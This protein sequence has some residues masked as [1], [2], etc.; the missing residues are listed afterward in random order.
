MDRSITQKSIG[1]AWQGRRGLIW[2]GLLFAG[3]GAFFLVG[4]FGP[5]IL[6]LVRSRN[7][8]ATPCVIVSRDVE[9]SR[10]SDGED[11]YRVVA[12][13]RYQVDGREYVGN[14]DNWSFGDSSGHE[15][16]RRIV[17][18]L[19]AG[20]DATCY[21][22]PANPAEA[23]LSR[24][25]GWEAAFV[26]IPV[27]FIVAG[28]GMMIAGIW[29]QPAKA[30]ANKAASNGR[31]TLG[32]GLV[33][34]PQVESGWVGVWPPPAK[35]RGP[36]VLS[37]MDT[38]AG[39]VAAVLAVIALI[40]NG[41]IG[42]VLYFDVFGHGS[43]DGF[44]I[45]G[46][47]FITPFVLVGIAL[48]AGVGYMLLAMKNPRP[49]VTIARSILR[50]GEMVEVGW[51]IEGRADWI[52]MLNLTLEGRESATRGSGENSS[53]HK[54]VFARIDIAHV[55]QVMQIASGRAVLRLPERSTPTFRSGNNSVE[56]ML[57]IHG[58]IPYW[59]DVKQEFTLDVFGPQL[60]EVGH[61][62]GH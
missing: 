2:G 14:R 60:Q 17:R 32:Q 33:S 26:L 42:C 22:D 36:R 10:N 37:S 21:V 41:I 62:D 24:E 4:A 56:W 18:S 48:V 12:R 19:P 7:W 34:A 46:A 38:P 39:Q 29:A 28:V 59:P 55:S 53:M 58:E 20:M 23:V 35:D 47:I 8:I 16:K 27:V 3:M 43:F 31:I 5:M 25:V 15:S 44:G 11:S 13:Y 57:V 52:T 9:E 61:A 1:W 40:W 6:G 50:L 49:V 30:I 51:K 54:H 45:F